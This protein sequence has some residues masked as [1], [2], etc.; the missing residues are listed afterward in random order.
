MRRLSPDKE[1]LPVNLHLKFLG[2]GSA[3]NYPSFW[4]QCSNCKYARTHGGRNIRRSSAT[5]LDDKILIDLPA[6]IYMFAD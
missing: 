5:L 6:E 1:V 4:C 3:E 2:T